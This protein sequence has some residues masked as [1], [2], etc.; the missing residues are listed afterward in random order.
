LFPSTTLFGSE[1]GAELRVVNRYLRTSFSDAQRAALRA[2]LREG[3]I[4]VVRV[5]GLSV[6]FGLVD[7]DE[8][9]NGLAEVTEHAAELEPLHALVAL[10]RIRDRRVQVVARSRS[11]LLDVGGAVRQAVGG[12]GHAAAAA[13]TVKGGDAAAVRAAILAA[14]ES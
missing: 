13:A 14:L 7:L 8:A 5:R 12:G 9:P 2:L 11:P 3:A 10:Y 6:G 4:E 1:R